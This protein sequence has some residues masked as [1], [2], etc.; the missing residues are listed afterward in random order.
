MLLHPPLVSAAEMRS[1]ESQ[2]FAAGIAEEGL[3]DQ[4][5]T[6]LADYVRKWL[7][8]PGAAV[9]FAG[10]GHN[11]GDAFGLAGHLLTAGWRV[12]V[13]LTFPEATLRPLAARKLAAIRD[14]VTFAEVVS[15]SLPAGRPLLLVEGLQIPKLFALL[16]VIPAVV[17]LQFALNKRFAF[18]QTKLDEPRLP[19]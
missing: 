7:P 16:P 4:A 9:V 10:K 15:A 17:I 2:A 8:Q 1:L 5:V 18:Q 6:G 3:M 19:S 12:Q 11:A 13:R 14:R